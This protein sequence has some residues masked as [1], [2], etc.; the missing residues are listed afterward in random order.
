MAG[1]G[2]V[3]VDFL[4]EAA[5]AAPGRPALDD[6]LRTWSYA[7]LDHEVDR[8][9]RGLAGA[10]LAPG[11]RV[12]VLLGEGAEQVAALHAVP[13]AGCV[14][15]PL[16]SRLTAAELAAALSALDPAGVL[17]S[18]AT[19]ERAGEAVA[20]AGTAPALLPVERLL[21]GESPPGSPVETGEEATEAPPAREW[22]VLWTSGTGGQARGVA[23]TAANFRASALASRERLGLAPEDRWLLSLSPAHVGGLAL[24]LRAALTRS[25]LV[26]RGAFS[27]A[28]FNALVDAGLVS[29]ASL[30]PTMLH[31]VLEA[32]GDRPIPPS[33]RCVLVGGARA[34]AELVARAL[35]AGLP[36]ALTYG[37]TEA[38]SQVA[39]APPA[40]VRAEPDTVGEPLP[41]VEV[42]VDPQGEILVR[43]PTV[44]LRYVGTHLPLTDAEGWVH[45][46][47]LG[48][49]DGRGRLV[50]SGRRTDRIVTGGVNVDPA[51]VEDV[52]RLSEGVRE[53]SVVGLPDPEWGELVAAA[54]V[55]ASGAWPDASELAALARTRLTA[56]K[57][58][59]RVVF[60]EGLPRNANGKVD[61]A[62]VR[63]LFGDL[64]AL[65][66]APTGGAGR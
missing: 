59:R 43:G 29:H 22:A 64:D 46:G 57:I 62:A 32:R 51:E 47:D 37:L 26:T 7:E 1:V 66:P 10:G 60:V 34:P 39:T 33:L 15:A 8:L 24:V 12:A 4:R 48:V 28:S 2:G 16:G 27:E 20:L 49:L 9:A 3:G 25:T 13:R 35:R 36:I 21:S 58:P 52:L 54:V 14:L 65:S 56:A 61:R 42:R 50:V 45:T 11:R 44:G 6:G 18:R 5:A 63:A 17:V 31:R 40:E 19:G 38:C 55:R 30:V 53:V 23:F 41:G